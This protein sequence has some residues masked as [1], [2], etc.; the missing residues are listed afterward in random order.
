MPKNLLPQVVGRQTFMSF[1]PELPES[2]DPSDLSFFIVDGQERE[3]L[4]TLEG[5]RGYVGII[6]GR[7][8]IIT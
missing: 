8:H 7:L 5:V 3:L 4:L 2:D 6:A 1:K